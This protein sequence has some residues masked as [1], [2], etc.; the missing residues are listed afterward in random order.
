MFMIMRLFAMAPKI[1]VKR[2]NKSLD[3]VHFHKSEEINQKGKQ[4]NLRQNATKRANML[5]AIR[6]DRVCATK[7][8]K[9]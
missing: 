3:F 7:N 1:C 6:I 5:N 4:T 2:D 9:F 8:G